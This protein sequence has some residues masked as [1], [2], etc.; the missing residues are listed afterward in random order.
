MNEFQGKGAW[1]FK[2]DEDSANQECTCMGIGIKP[3]SRSNY[4][5]SRELWM[6]RCVVIKVLSSWLAA[7]ISLS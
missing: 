7:C 5:G 3:V 1:E 4:D 2:L 6:Y